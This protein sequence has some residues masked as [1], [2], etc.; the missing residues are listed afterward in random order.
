MPFVF[1]RP[2]DSIDIFAAPLKMASLP[3]GHLRGV[4][5]T[6]GSHRVMNREDYELKWSIIPLNG[7]TGNFL[8][9][10]WAGS[11]GVQDFN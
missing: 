11:A 5:T 7:F 2:F 4:L 8:G 3:V 9:H 10:I 6:V 1:F